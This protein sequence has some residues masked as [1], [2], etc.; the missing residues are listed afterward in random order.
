M[1]ILAEL[2]NK[3]VCSSVVERHSD[4]MEVEGSIP[5]TP[6]KLE[7]ADFGRFVAAAGRRRSRPPAC[8]TPKKFLKPFRLFNALDAVGKLVYFQKIL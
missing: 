5:S 3:R 1:E 4:K 7:V 2:K 8:L 6:T